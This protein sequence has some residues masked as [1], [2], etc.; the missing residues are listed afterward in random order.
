M[1]KNQFVRPWLPLRR[2]SILSNAAVGPWIFKNCWCPLPVYCWWLFGAFKH[3]K[4]NRCVFQMLEKTIQ[5]T[6]SFHPKLW[7]MKYFMTF[8]DFL[9]GKVKMARKKT[10]A[11]WTVFAA[12]SWV[13]PRRRRSRNF[14]PSLRLIDIRQWSQANLNA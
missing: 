7:K 8:H 3:P 11:Y 1:T 13:D 4:Y 6:T 10:L 12:S 2:P 14:L 9:F 5:L